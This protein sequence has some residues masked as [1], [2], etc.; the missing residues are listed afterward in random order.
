MKRHTINKLIFCFFLFSCCLLVGLPVHSGED[1]QHDPGYRYICG[2]AM[3]TGCQ[4]S[5]DHPGKCPCGK[6][7]FKK[8]I[9]KEDEKYYYISRSTK[10][11]CDCSE[12]S[13]DKT[14]C[15]CGAELFALEKKP[16]TT[17]DCFKNGGCVLNKDGEEGHGG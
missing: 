9:I 2:C 3:A 8:K 6:P 11:G 7:L 1:H 10:S 14:K 17:Y 13:E 4:L 15:R 16:K 12:H 5:Y